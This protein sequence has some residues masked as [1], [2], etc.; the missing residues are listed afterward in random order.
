MSVLPM[1]TEKAVMFLLRS[2][3]CH[4]QNQNNR[5][6]Q[7]N[8]KNPGYKQ[9]QKSISRTT[10]LTAE[11]PP[12]KS[13]V[14]TWRQLVF[15]NHACR[16]T[17]HFLSDFYS[18]FSVFFPFFFWRVTVTSQASG[19]L[20]T[21]SF[22]VPQTSWNCTSGRSTFPVPLWSLPIEEL[23]FWSCQKQK[24]WHFTS[25]T[26]K[27]P[28]WAWRWLA[29]QRVSSVQIWNKSCR[30]KYSFSQSEYFET[31]T[32][33]NSARFEKGLFHILVYFEIP[34]AEPFWVEG[35]QLTCLEFFVSVWKCKRFVPKKKHFA[36]TQTLQTK[37][38]DCL[39]SPPPLSKGTR[40]PFP[41]QTGGFWTYI[42]CCE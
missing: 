26:I 20:C 23:F 16:S 39:V 28:L 32:K 7:K 19:L 6:A 35:A 30:P 15:E 27:T 10:G 22:L 13:A 40:I 29:S 34:L 4:T 2:T 25:C 11:F 31:C 18:V 33:Q 37:K 12:S 41:R 24:V 42:F 3:C 36:K 17:L 21:Q 8:R 1:E 5:N 14:R 9:K 38:K